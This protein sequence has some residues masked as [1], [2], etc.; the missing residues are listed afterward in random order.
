MNE[1]LRLS[2]LAL[3]ALGPGDQA[4]LLERLPA[5]NRATLEQLMAELRHT[6]I[7]RD[8]EVVRRLVNESAAVPVEARQSLA[9]LLR[10]DAEAVWAELRAEPDTVVAHVLARAQWPWH[11]ALL[12]LTDPDRAANIKRLQATLPDAPALRKMLCEALTQRLTEREQKSPRSF[13]R[14]WWPRGRSRA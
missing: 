8:G 1:G 13:S 12:S 9:S 7:P 3:H 2:A 6:G 11:R 14:R 5:D 4:W 10:A